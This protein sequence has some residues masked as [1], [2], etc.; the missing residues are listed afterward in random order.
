[1]ERRLGH[2]AGEFDHHLNGDIRQ[3]QPVG[4]SVGKR[5][6]SGSEQNVADGE[7]HDDDDAPAPETTTTRAVANR[8]PGGAHTPVDEG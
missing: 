7:K 1:M 2:Q 5:R 6:R 3:V 8:L 4:Q